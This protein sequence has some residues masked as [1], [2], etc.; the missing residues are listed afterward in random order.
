VVL[1]APRPPHRVDDYVAAGRAMQR[2]WLAAT[3]LGLQLQPELT[4]LIFARYVRERRVFSAKPG[5]QQDAA[6]LAGQAEQLIGSETLE[7]AVFMAR[8][9]AGAAAQARSIRKPLHE[10][11]VAAAPA[12]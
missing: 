5:M 10:L 2:F 11:I 7:R 4:P 3:T 1:T 12:R 9:G 8:I 6:A